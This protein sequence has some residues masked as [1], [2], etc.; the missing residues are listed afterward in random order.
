M[1]WRC[2]ACRAVNHGPIAA[3]LDPRYGWGLCLTCNQRRTFV[4]HAEPA[5]GEALKAEGMAK[6]ALNADQGTDAGW[7]FRALEVAK[8]LIAGG[9]P[10]TMDDIVDQVGMPI[11]RN[12]T[13]SL[14]SGLA[15]Q[16]LI[17]RVGVVKGKRD[18][19]HSRLISVWQRSLTMDDV[20]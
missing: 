8:T 20:A 7:R 11:H 4:Q 9:R 14:L 1:T 18:S 13:G 15:R 19:Q 2:A 12:A 17:E 16:G 3:S 6:A 10:F 5:E